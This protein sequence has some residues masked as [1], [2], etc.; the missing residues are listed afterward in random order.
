MIS[1]ILNGNWP[2]V[3]QKKVTP[4][5]QMS[6]ACL[7]ILSNSCC[8]P[9]Y[10]G[11]MNYNVPFPESLF[12]ISVLSIFC[13]A[14]LPKSANFGLLHFVKIFCGFISQCA[15][16]RSWRNLIAFIMSTNESYIFSSLI[17]NLLIELF[18]E[19]FL[20]IVSN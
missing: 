17:V 1:L 7:S 14:K 9:R 18:F 10:S 20:D 8:F 15:K 11:D 19:S 2:K 12:T 16:L 5:A 13:Y 4:S 3:M 6:K